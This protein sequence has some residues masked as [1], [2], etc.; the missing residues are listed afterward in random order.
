MVRIP[1]SV[2]DGSLPEAPSPFF[3]DQDE[4]PSPLLAQYEQLCHGRLDKGTIEEDD[5]V[6]V[7][8]HPASSTYHRGCHGDGMG[9]GA[10]QKRR[11]HYD[12][13]ATRGSNRQLKEK[14]GAA[15]FL[16]RQ[17][18]GSK[19]RSSAVGGR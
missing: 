16:S 10:G 15:T 4:E 14:L 13:K 6:R 3:G 18:A 9:E 11:T 5:Q 8:E 7:A 2:S 19:R 1:R 17:T 12:G